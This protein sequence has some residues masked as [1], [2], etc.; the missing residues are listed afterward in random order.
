VTQKVPSMRL[1]VA[2]SREASA[3]GE[4]NTSE[5]LWSSAPVSH[6]EEGLVAVRRHRQSKV[7]EAHAGQILQEI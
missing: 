1:S 3:V 6:N 4:L 5:R 2:W 7:G